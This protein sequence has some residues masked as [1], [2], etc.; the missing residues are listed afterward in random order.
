MDCAVVLNNA[1]A[2]VALR[3]GDGWSGTLG[4]AETP[5]LPAALGDVE[6]SGPADLLAGHLPDLERDVRAPLAAAGYGPERIAALGEG[7]GG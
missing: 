6:V 7:P 1:G 5:L 3:C 4:R 2:P